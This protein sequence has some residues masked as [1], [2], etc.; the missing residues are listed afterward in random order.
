MRRHGE[1]AV[2]AAVVVLLQPRDGG[3]VEHLQ[4]E[5][6]NAFELSHQARF[7][8]VP[9]R[10]DLAVLMG[11][12]A[13]RGD[14]RDAEAKQPLGDL[15]R[16]HRRAVVGEQGPRQ[17][18]LHQRL[19]QPVDEHFGGLGEVPLKVAP[20]ARVV[21]EEA[22]QDRRL[23][24]AR[25]GQHAAL[26]FVHV[27]VPQGMAARDFVAQHLARLD[28]RTGLALMP[29]APALPHQPASAHRPGQRRVRRHRAER[30][31]GVDPRRQVLVVELRRPRRMRP[32]LLAQRLDQR[33]RHRAR[34]P[35]IGARAPLERA[36]RVVVLSPRLVVPALDGGGREAHR[37]RTA[38]VI[39]LALG[40]PLQLRAQLPLRRRRGQ[41]R[42]HHREAQ[43]RPPL[44]ELARVVAVHC[45]IPP[46][47][48]VEVAMMRRPIGAG[49]KRFL[50]AMLD[51][52]R[53]RKHRSTASARPDCAAA[54]PSGLGP[55]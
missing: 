16:G 48:F 32:V 55:A 49:Q 39:P 35:G 13:E 27:G 31:V 42:P 14:P 23:P 47:C 12:V 18:A 44:A 11:A 17:A 52:R 45:A 30:G 26:A 1:L 21:V 10:F 37:P 2:R 3:V 41:K 6:V 20:Q 34:A 43:P 29:L 8:G 25:S 50:R 5:R 9:E 36:H 38:R 24:F 22:E 53:A 15:A 51:R 28:R 19:A 40:Q 46:R 54:A 33:R 7:D 4:G